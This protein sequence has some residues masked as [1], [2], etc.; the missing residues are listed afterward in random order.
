[1]VHRSLNVD[2]VAFFA[3]ESAYENYARC[4]GMGWLNSQN[5]Q[6]RSWGSSMMRSPTRWVQVLGNRSMPLS[7]RLQN[8]N[9]A[10]ITPLLLVLSNG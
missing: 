7:T 4:V 10:L 6:A 9:Q 2:I 5:E 3:S 8:T 1:M